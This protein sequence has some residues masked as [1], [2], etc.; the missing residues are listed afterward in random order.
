MKYSL[1]TIEHAV[2]TLKAGKMVI[3]MDDEDRENEGDLVV[4]ADYATPEVINFMSRH[5][6]GLI[7]LSMAD[8]L[9]DKL[10][11]PMMAQ[12]NRSPYGTAF[13]VSIEAA[14]GVS[15]GI[16]AKDR[17]QTI[18][19][20]IAAESGPT[21]VIS[22]GHV[23]PLR[24]KKK[25]VLE[26]PGQTEGSVDLA[27]LAGLTPAAVICEIINEDGTMSRRDELVAFSEKYNIPLVTIKDLIEYRIR[28]E[29]LVK[30][31]ASTRIPLQDKGDFNM[32]VFANELDCA[33]HFA[34]VKPPIF[35]NR[36]PL[37]R[38][39]S[40]CIT[41]DIFGSCKCDCGNQ[42]EQSLSLIAAE[43]G[44][45]IYLRQEGR[46]I[47]LANKLKAYALQEQGWDTVDANHQLGLPAD[48][49]NYAVAYQII[50]YF[51]IDAIRLLTNN[52]SKIAAVECY[53]VKVM[54]RVPLEIEPTK[55]SHRY[56]KTKKEK[57]G[58]LL[59]I[60]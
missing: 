36:A 33:E 55:E 3:L 27:K 41:G 59:A 7:C 44:V 46:G 15:T 20:A 48:S 29:M 13:T 16:S 26:R 17:A 34:L 60:T 22:P 6:C 45:L 53:G 21:D 2:E 11:L 28:H 40:E 25:G 35:A 47:G 8:E 37:V 32:T 56:L 38:I 43:G 14:E 1:A 51:G 52:P 31:A 23:F 18:K 49:R 5:G 30:A 57:M 58:H 9:I 54:E 12:N 10:Q 39:H 24:A 42:L 4:A 19:V 50:K